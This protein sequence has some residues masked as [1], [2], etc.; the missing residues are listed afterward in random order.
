MQVLT[1]PL[2]IW[3]KNSIRPGPV[4]GVGDCLISVRLKQSAPDLNPRYEERYYG[5]NE[6]YYG[7]N[8]SDGRSAGFTSGG[9]VAKTLQKPLGYRRGFKTA[10]GWVHEDLRPV[11]RAMTSL[12]GS[13]GQ[14]GWNT[15]VAR[16]VRAKTT[17]DN[18]LPLPQG[19]QLDP[20]EIPRGS[21]IPIIVAE[22]LGEGI[23]LPATELAVKDPRFGTGGS[24]VVDTGNHVVPDY[25]INPNVY[26]T[27]ASNDPRRQMNV[28]D[29]HDRHPDFNYAVLVKPP[30][31]FYRAVL[32]W[33]EDSPN[34]QTLYKINSSNNNPEFITAVAGPS[35]GIQRPAG[36]S[37]PTHQE[38]NKPIEIAK[39]TFKKPPATGKKELK[40]SVR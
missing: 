15:K 31:G 17:G 35:G 30:W 26:W 37:I 36:E 5:K 18:F 4:G 39:P 33:P 21:Q 9:G 40:S 2:N 32:D 12:S 20:G 10:V 3:D 24:V 13:V 28:W 38:K 19:Y 7:A 34:P 16:V 11:D 23:A 8:V 6:K 25:E 27:P 29:W 1:A 22:S 14:Y